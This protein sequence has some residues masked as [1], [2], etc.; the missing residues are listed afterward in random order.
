MK[1]D[2]LSRENAR[3][4]SASP[5]RAPAFLSA[6]VKTSLA[7]SNQEMSICVGSSFSDIFV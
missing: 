4:V 5:L 6:S 3:R 1:P 7:P 2:V